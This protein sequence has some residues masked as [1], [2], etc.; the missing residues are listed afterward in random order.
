MQLASTRVRTEW[1]WRSRSVSKARLSFNPG[2]KRIGRLMTQAR[3]GLIANNGLATTTQL[4]G[5]AYP[6][7]R[8]H[9]HCDELRR[10]L[11]QLGAREL[12]RANSTGRP[13][14]WEIGRAHV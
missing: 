3:R 12:G 8:K 11:R 2:K 7:V 9:W 4:L 1:N 6:H 5:W 14:I 10:S 13:I